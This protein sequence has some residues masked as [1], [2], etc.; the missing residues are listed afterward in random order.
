MSL[1]DRIKSKAISKLGSPYVFGTQGPRTFDCSGLVFWIYR[2]CDTDWKTGQTWP[3]LTA[4]GFW[5]YAERISQP[6]QVGD[7]CFWLGK[8]GKAYHIGIYVGNGKTV[9]ARGRR[10]GVVC[11]DLN[12]P[13]HGTIK[14][15][16]VWG[17]FS[18]VKP[19]D[20]TEED[21][22]KLERTVLFQNRVSAVASSYSFNILEAQIIGDK[23]QAERLKK[24]RAVEVEKV[25]VYLG[26]SKEQALEA[27][28]GGGG[29]V[30]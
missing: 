13:I 3:R 26:L 18:W 19:G 20:L 16:A 27:V 7:C 10:W 22:D 5:H 21:M 14:R 23:A 25:R 24:E 11:Y 2:T 15:K 17:R 30:T 1:A 9:E 4:H 12:D 6:T 28:S 8:S 29:V